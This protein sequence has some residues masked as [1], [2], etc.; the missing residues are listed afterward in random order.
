METIHQRIKRLRLAKGWSHK[1]LAKEIE[2]ADGPL[3]SYQSIQQW[4]REDEKG[5]TAPRRKIEPYVAKAL[6]VSH[7]ELVVG[8]PEQ[9]ELKDIY[10]D[11]DAPRQRHA[12]VV[13]PVGALE[14]DLFSYLSRPNPPYRQLAEAL[15]IVLRAAEKELRGNGRNH[16]SAPKKPK[17]RKGSKGASS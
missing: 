15:E 4:E 16:Q 3:L 14:R 7:H 17:H 11:D 1:T 2:R 13:K 8:A 6:G 9:G 10:L 5:G 12:K